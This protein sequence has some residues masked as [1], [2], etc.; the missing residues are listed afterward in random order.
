M[1]E[2]ARTSDG[3]CSN[4]DVQTTESR[5][6]ADVDQSRPSERTST[7]WTSG[8]GVPRQR[9]AFSEW[10]EKEWV[11]E[12]PVVNDRYRAMAVPVLRS[13]TGC[14]RPLWDVGSSTME[15]PREWR[16]AICKQEVLARPP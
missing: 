16:S 6:A 12:H 10:G 14:V 4:L 5:G 3:S 13:N 11:C 8:Q 2:P 7:G 9:L 1:Y 15:T